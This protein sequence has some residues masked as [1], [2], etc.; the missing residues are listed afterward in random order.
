MIELEHDGIR[1]P[2]VNTWVR[3]EVPQEVQGAL[4]PYLA[5]AFA[6]LIDVALPVPCV[7][8]LLVRRAAWSAE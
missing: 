6:S 5:A 1:L 2:A 3:L 7:V 4:E 8:L